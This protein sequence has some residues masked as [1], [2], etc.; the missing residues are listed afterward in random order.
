M[1]KFRAFW[2]FSYLCQGMNFKDIAG[3]RWPDI[4][5]STLSFMRQK[6]KN[7]NKA[8]QKKV[9]VQLEQ[10]VLDI[11]DKWGQMDTKPDGYVFPFFTEGMTEERKRAVCKQ[12]IKNINKWIKKIA[13]LIEFDVVP[14]FMYARHSYATILRNTRVSVDFISQALGHSTLDTTQNYLDS[15]EANKVREYNSR[16][17]DMGYKSKLNVCHKAGQVKTLRAISQNT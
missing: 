2:I 11:I 1:E 4:D 6:T 10:A 3:I 9:V 12:Q 15:F 8:H 17:L 5:G 16:L 7:K 14:T 13:K